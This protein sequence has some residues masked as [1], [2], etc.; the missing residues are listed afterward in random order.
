MQG[1]GPNVMEALRERP[2]PLLLIGLC[3]ALFCAL[4][5]YHIVWGGLLPAE[6]GQAAWFLAIAS[7]VGAAAC[8]ALYLYCII[9]KANS[10]AR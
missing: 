1:Q 4:M 6:A 3:E 8:I 7:G 9:Q 10:D 2:L 5:V